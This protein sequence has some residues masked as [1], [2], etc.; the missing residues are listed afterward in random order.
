MSDR[1]AVNKKISPH[2]T[3]AST[4]RAQ[5]EVYRRGQTPISDETGTVRAWNI[6]PAN[7]L[8]TGRQLDEIRGN[9]GAEGL[10]RTI[11]GLAA[12]RG[13]EFTAAALRTASPEVM[14]SAANVKV[15]ADPA[16]ET[17]EAALGSEAGQSLI[18]KSG[19]T[20]LPGQFSENL[21]RATGHSFDRVRVHDDP[22]A[23]AAAVRLNAR[24]FTVGSDIYFARGDYQPSTPAGQHLLAHEAAHTVQ[25]SGASMPA[26]QDLKVTSPGDRDEIEAEQFAEAVVKGN[27]SPGELSLTP[28]AKVAR[29]Q[30][31]ISF[32]RS[33]DAFTTNDMTVNSA[34]AGF[35]I[36]PA[37][38]P[39]FQ[40]SADVTINGN[41]GDPFANFEV[42]PLQV[43][44]GFWLNVYWGTGADRTKKTGQI[45]TLPSRDEAP[46]SGSPWYSNRRAS[47]TFGASG[48]V[49]STTMA[50][51][52][53]WVREP[54][55][56]PL[57]PRAS[58][59]GW[60]NYGVSFVAYISARDRIVG[61]TADAYRATGCVYWN[62]SIDGHW[63]NADPVA[64]RMS[65]TG[66]T[67][68]RSGVIN[69]ASGEYPS[70]HGGAAA[71]TF[72]TT[73]TT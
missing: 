32:A 11:Q 47:A 68:N 43:V 48:D 45:T 66:G 27:T 44:R 18:S 70:M 60:F 52:P 63:D 33:N 64:T 6:P 26:P 13:P 62:V 40:W 10:S 67:V 3:S 54:W 15:G 57:P 12:T 28:S 37:A 46:G 34:A 19:G 14:R 16:L 56:N 73:T 4:L 39:L 49:R 30:R 24:A 21:S 36:R 25:Q 65:T 5:A 61:T 9:F 72:L 7:A 41:A 53:Q 8:Q 50:D 38:T 51:S 59:R 71:I 1:I 35:Q 31:V 22:S 20:P 2:S 17:E 55:D 23:H 42:G 58:T 69:G 29:I